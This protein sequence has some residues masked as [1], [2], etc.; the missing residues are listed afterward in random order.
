M[1]MAWKEELKNDLQ[2]VFD[3]FGIV[4]DNS[5]FYEIPSGVR[6]NTSISK[7]PFYF[8][9]LE[10][11]VIRSTGRSKLLSWSYATCSKC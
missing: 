9:L 11:L 1:S 3:D 10:Y 2:E 7:D 6:L 4:D 5:S 8:F